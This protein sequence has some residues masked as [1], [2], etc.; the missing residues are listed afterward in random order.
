MWGN[1]SSAYQL[2]NIPKPVRN[3]SL[4]IEIGV[5][6]LLSIQ[7]VCWLAVCWND[8]YILLVHLTT[9]CGEIQSS[10]YQLT[11]ILDIQL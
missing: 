8:A 1:Q 10:A 2:T 7:F 3:A 11:N 4:A 6:L 9:K 5:Y